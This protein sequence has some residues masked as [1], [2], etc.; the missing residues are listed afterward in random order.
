MTDVR[1]DRPGPV[2]TPTAAAAPVWAVLLVFVV[3][4]AV[5]SPLL[6]AVQDA[7]G[8]PTSVIVLTQLATACGALVVWALWRG[9]VPAPAVTTRGWS[10]PSLVSLVAAAGVGGVVLLVA[11]LT[12][13]RWPVLDPA[14]LPAP[15]AV[16][17]VLQ[18]VGA[19][20]EEVGWRGVVQP[21]L[22]TRLRLVPA[23]VVTGLLFGLG[24]L[25]V[26]AAGPVVYGLFVVAAVGLSLLLATLT[27]GR[28]VGQRVV[29]ATVL[30]WLVNLV[31]LIGFSGGDESV[32]WMLATA[33]VTVS[34]GAGCAVLA[35]RGRNPF[36][37]RPPGTT[38]P[39]R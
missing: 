4:S 34:L 26:A 24:H 15:L 20:G 12:G 35:A 32:T 7:T 10:R 29:L 30:H 2:P 16:V 13:S 31:L 36:G 5:A 19:A 1:S 38:P 21:A 23:A 6:V 28:G 39:G 33:A 8:W 25:H 22:E 17:L 9:R 3:V 11:A 27:A 18:L 37:G 14:T